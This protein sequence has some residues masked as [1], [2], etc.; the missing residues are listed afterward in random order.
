MPCIF[1]TLNA[2]SYELGSC[3]TLYVA[4]EAIKLTKTYTLSDF[5]SKFFRTKI[6][7]NYFD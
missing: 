3:Y 7:L 1:K 5:M 2:L 6:K 4:L